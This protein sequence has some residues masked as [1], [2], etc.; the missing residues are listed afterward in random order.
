MFFEDSMNLYPDSHQI[1]FK[2]SLFLHQKLK[3]PIS[4]LLG[5]SK[6]DSCQC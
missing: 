6:T 4:L 5:Y 2:I 3:F 1:I